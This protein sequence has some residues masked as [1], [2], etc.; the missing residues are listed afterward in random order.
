MECLGDQCPC[1][2]GERVHPVITVAYLPEVGAYHTVKMRCAAIKAEARR[3][4]G[5]HDMCGEQATRQVG[6]LM[7]CDYHY[8]RVRRW[9][10][11][12]NGHFL[13]ADLE[14]ARK[15]HEEQVRLDRERAELARVQNKETARQRA[16]DARELAKEQE[17]LARERVA[18][19]E[20]ARAAASVVYFVRRESDG[21]IKIGTTRRLADR[22]GKLRGAFGPLYL[23]ATVGGAHKEEHA[24]HGQFADL[25]ADGEWFQPDLV[26]LEHVY[27]VRSDHPIDPAPR[28][29]LMEPN[30]I[31]VMIRRIKEERATEARRQR[32]EK[33]NERAA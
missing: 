31:G 10:N 14:S 1:R 3:G 5:A 19:E 15:L 27:R 29:P 7:V 12:A 8:K 11:E 32:W 17:R 24:L 20:A 21:C 25:R 30:D 26:L 18:A 13:A 4:D 23:M 16:A 2:D 22:L 28:L 9:M 6:D 33:E